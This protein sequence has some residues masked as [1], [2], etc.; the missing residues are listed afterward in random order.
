VAKDSLQLLDLSGRDVVPYLEDGAVCPKVLLLS[1]VRSKPRPDAS[2]RSHADID[3]IESPDPRAMLVQN[4]DAAHPAWKSINV[5]DWHEFLTALEEP[6]WADP[7]PAFHAP[8]LSPS[9]YN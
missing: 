8:P 6:K 9:N 7:R 1:S 2:L 5:L 3:D 4:I